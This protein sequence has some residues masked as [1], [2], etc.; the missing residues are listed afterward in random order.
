MSIFV[1]ARYY[2][3]QILLAILTSYI[4]RVMLPQE[5]QRV[6]KCEFAAISRYISETVQA[7][8]K[9]TIECE[10]EV[11]GYCLIIYAVLL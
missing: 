5:S 1:N 2:A 11:V 8:A 10:Y 9:V 4:N 7:S 6:V 3:I